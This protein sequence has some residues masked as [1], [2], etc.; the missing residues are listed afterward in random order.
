MLY[1]VI[2]FLLLPFVLPVVI[3]P[4]LLHPGYRT[5]LRDRLSLQFPST[6]KGFPTFWIHA[7]SMGEIQAA[8]PLV[9]NIQDRFP[10]AKLIFTTLTL[11]GRSYIKKRL[12][13]DVFWKERSV[14]RLMPLDLPFIVRRAVRRLMPDILLLIETELWPN[15]IQSV[16]DKGIPIAVVS[17]RISSRSFRRYRWI[18]F[19]LQSKLRLIE[20]F[21]MQTDQDAERLKSL[22]VPP[23]RIQVTGSLKLD[24]EI[25]LLSVDTLLE[26]RRRWHWHS[27]DQI[28]VAGSTRPG[29]EENIILA[30]RSLKT[31][32]PELR[33]IIAPRHLDRINEVKKLLEENELNFECLSQK[34]PGS[35][36]IIL[37]DTMGQL[38]QMYQ[39]AD[40]VFVGGTLVP[41]GGHDLSEPALLGKP[42]IYGPFVDNIQWLAESLEKAG[43]GFRVT[44]RNSLEQVLENFL[45]DHELT[46]SAGHQA[47]ETISGLRGAIHRSSEGLLDLLE[48]SKVRSIPSLDKRV[49]AH[50][51]LEDSIW[52][53]HSGGF[54]A[55]SRLGLRPLSAA[56]HVL[57]TAKDR[58]Y[59]VGIL[60]SKNLSKPVISVGNITV[61]GTGKTPTVIAICQLL[62]RRG[63]RPVLLSR[64]YQGNNSSAYLEVSDGK[65]I[66]RSADVV[67]DEPVLLARKLPNIPIFIG[68]DR[69]LSGQVAISKYQPDVLILDDG[70]QHRRLHRDLDIVLMDSGQPFGNETILPLG[71]LREPISYLERADCFLITRVQSSQAASALISHLK[72]LYPDKP[73]FLSQHRMT[74]IVPVSR[75]LSGKVQSFSLLK[76]KRVTVVAGIANPDFLIRSLEQRGLEVTSICRFPDH[77]RYKQEDVEWVEKEA[78]KMGSDIILTT[79]K[80]SMRLELL[81]RSMDLWWAITMELA[82]MDEKIWEDQILQVV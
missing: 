63:Y 23:Y 34:V 57:Q 20:R 35:Q 43:G 60:K 81:N 76:G 77:Y 31:K 67:G 8:W 40:F 39:L 75:S 36:D 58:S 79:E 3:I 41:V 49:G 32:F 38:T 51:W 72:E 61:G 9:K 16:H 59:K 21:F 56:Y 25:E 37:V 2:L 69:T 48:A 62:L 54:T 28:F 24:R 66:K 6:T 10:N 7:A 33:L 71:P 4:V 64:G 52:Q 27:S 11:T 44:D 73:S 13:E 50:R 55:L 74:G 14:V 78:K 30:F 47:R 22:G 17:G 53:M 5:G 18:R 42:V 19:S 80:D 65:E 45:S 46:L 70:F 12:S 29:E 15:F 26:F 1:N 68:R 82:L